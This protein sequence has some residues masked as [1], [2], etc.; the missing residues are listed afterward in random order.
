MLEL[1]VLW[2]LSLPRVQ[3]SQC[4]DMETDRHGD[5]ETQGKKIKLIIGV[6]HYSSRIGKHIDLPGIAVVCP[7]LGPFQNPVVVSREMAQVQTLTDPWLWGGTDAADEHA[8][9]SRLS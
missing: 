2:F 3:R 6:A 7:S 9:L 1:C 8:L 5:R 4:T